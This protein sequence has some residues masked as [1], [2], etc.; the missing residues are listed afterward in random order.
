[1]SM[2]AQR[3][4]HRRIRAKANDATYEI[5]IWSPPVAPP[6]QGF[7]VIYVLDANALFGT[8][9]E[10]VARASRRPEATAVSSAVVV[11]IG[12][13]GDDLY[14]VEIRQENFTAAPA[15]GAADD[16]PTRQTGGADAFLSF[17]RNELI[18]DIEHEFPI[19]PSRR[20]L[21]G[22]S[23]AGYF[24]LLA[25]TRS[26]ELFRAYVAVSPSIW[27][28]E[29]GLRSGLSALTF[30]AAKVFIAVGEWEGT[31]PP[32]QRQHQGHEEI[33]ARREQRQMI[34]N[35][36]RFSADLQTALGSQNV[37]FHEFPGE[38]HIS[39]LLISIG[40]ALRFALT[41]SQS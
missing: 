3:C 39:V 35:A 33:S 26:P 37:V 31:L 23:L 16:S 21:F 19:D 38:D 20:I 22:H 1:M 5:R 6:T 32:W 34:G 36:R 13:P 10:A 7:P 28:D 41:P 9:V 14:P 40:R 15:S 17:I 18:A 30:D 11:G 27:W 25:L 4:V 8:F 29:T 12:Y 24:V 2:A